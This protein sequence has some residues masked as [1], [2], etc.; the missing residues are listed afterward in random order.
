MVSTLNGEQGLG[1]RANFHWIRQVVGHVFPHIGWQVLFSALMLGQLKRPYRGRKPKAMI[2]SCGI[3]F[4]LL[5]AHGAIAGACTHLG[6]ALTAISC[7]GFSYLG[8]QIEVNAGR[9]SDREILH[10]RPGHIHADDRCLLGGLS[11]RR[12]MTGSHGWNRTTGCSPEG[13]GGCIAESRSTWRSLTPSQP[14]LEGLIAADHH[15]MRIALF[16]EAYA[17][18]VNGVV[19]TQVELVRYLRRRGHEVLQAVPYYKAN[20][21]QE[22]VVEFRA[23]PFPLYPEMPIIL[24]HWR[25]HR[26]EFAESGSLQTGP[27]SSDE[28][29]RSGL[30][31]AA[32]GKTAWMPGGGILRN[33]YHPLYALLRFRHDSSLNSGVIC[34]GYLTIVTTPTSLPR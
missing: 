14:F 27:G 15:P 13:Q 17:P 29:G 4:G 18:Q 23:V 7:L 1:I 26:R 19:R 22:Q 24:P 20:P 16:S 5:F 30:F 32:L 8:Q 28:S 2:V 11:L 33:R 25:F 34:A 12:D 3:L 21:R 6:F 9:N 10:F 31:R